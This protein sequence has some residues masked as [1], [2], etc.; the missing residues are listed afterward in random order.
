MQNYLVQQISF[1]HVSQDYV[2][3]RWQTAEVINNKDVLKITITNIFSISRTDT[4][5][6]C[7]CVCVA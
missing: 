5:L 4:C 3:Q 7:F 6:C 2:P 1:T